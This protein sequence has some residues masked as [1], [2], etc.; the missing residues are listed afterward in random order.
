MLLLS[1]S[2]TLSFALSIH[3]DHDVTPG[4]LQG[5]R[6]SSRRS[7]GG[8][9]PGRQDERHWPR[10]AHA[11]PHAR[12][13]AAGLSLLLTPY[14]LPCITPLSLS[15]TL[16]L[17]L[18]LTAR[19]CRSIPISIGQRLQLRAAKPTFG[20]MAPRLPTVGLVD[21]PR[22]SHSKIGLKWGVWHHKV[23]EALKANQGQI[24]G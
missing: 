21:H 13:R 5:A 6:H 1:L 4:E 17:S 22:K 7:Q 8:R 3:R 2:L 20:R 16:H 10:G 12:H 24:D 14:A 15:L 11:R 9:G 18:S 23:A 19:S